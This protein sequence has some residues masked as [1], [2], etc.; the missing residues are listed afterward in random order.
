MGDGPEDIEDEIERVAVRQQ[1]QQVRRRALAVGIL[2]SVV[3]LL[4]P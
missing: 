1:A 3:L 4:L 2:V